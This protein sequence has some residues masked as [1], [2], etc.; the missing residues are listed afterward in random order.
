M[1]VIHGDKDYRV[2]FGQGLELWQDLQRLSPEL[3]HKFLYFPDEGHWVLKPA[4]A[5]MWYETFLEFL[6][7]HVKA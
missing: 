5:Q 2:P 7:T 3:E 1:L 4:N 6:D